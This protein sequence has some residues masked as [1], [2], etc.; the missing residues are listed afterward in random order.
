MPDTPQH[1]EQAVRGRVLPPAPF[2]A[3]TRPATESK[4]AEETSFSAE[5]PWIMD[6]KE[7][8]AP[9]VAAGAFPSKA[10]GEG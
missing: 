6:P 3:A 1:V 9:P 5:E 2:A 10:P 7:F 8:S 4:G